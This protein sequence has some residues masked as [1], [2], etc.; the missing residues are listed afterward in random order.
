MIL[1]SVI[2][3]T[4]ALVLSTSA[5]ATTVVGQMM[6]VEM[7][8][9]YNT[10]T[11]SS[12]ENVSSS[13]TFNVV[14][15]GVEIGGGNVLFG[16]YEANGGVN[17]SE[18]SISMTGFN[19]GFG[20]VAFNGYHFF[21]TNGTID[22][23]TSVT[24]TSQNIIGQDRINFSAD[25]IWINMS[26]LSLYGSNGFLDL[27]FTTSASV[28]TVPV[29]AAAWLFGSGLLGLAGLARRKKV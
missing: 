28:S 23:F 14:D 17:V 7:G 18:N 13:V 4:L 8:T 16:V 9:N 11:P 24:V 21:D 3:T 12:L 22:D 20:S 19:V 15:P 6:T 2:F 29:P 1:K 10:A 5:S 27:D 26:G 25:D